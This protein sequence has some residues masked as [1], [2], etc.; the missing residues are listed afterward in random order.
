MH[1]KMKA[2]LPGPI[3]T[4]AFDREMRK[5]ME[6]LV[7]EVKADFDKTV[8]TWNN[9]PKFVTSIRVSFDELRG[10]VR[11]KPISGRK[12]PELIYYFLSEGT[13]VRHAIMTGDFVPKSRPGVVDSFPGRG[14]LLR[15]DPRYDGPGIKARKWDEAIATKNRAKVPFRLAVALRNGAKTCGHHHT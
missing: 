10:R 15:V 9:K 6:K 4:R 5:E 1:I 2:I 11:T 8:A 3:D 7:K 12:P 14:G 13:K